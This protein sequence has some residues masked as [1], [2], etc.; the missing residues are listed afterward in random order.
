MMDD[1]DL[2][3]AP[4][5]DLSPLDPLAEARRFDGLAQRIVSD[6]MAARSAA[7]LTHRPLRS[8]VAEI[9]RWSL[10]ILAAAALVVVAAIPT[11]AVSARRLSS[12]DDLPLA[13]SDRLGFPAPVIALTQAGRQPTPADVIAA[14]DA[15]WLE[16]SR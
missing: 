1:E 6:G 4:P 13:Q 7:R 16:V 5:V 8:A 15:R 11:L 12:A 9:A 3:T 10:P 14:F 2:A